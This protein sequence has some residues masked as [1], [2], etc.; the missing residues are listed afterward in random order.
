MTN[1]DWLFEDKTIIESP[2]SPKQFEYKVISAKTACDLNAKWHSRLPIIDWSNV[3]RNT[4]SICFGAM[5]KGQW[6]AIAI[7][8]S[9]VAQN[10]F[11]YGKQILELRRMAIS[12]ACPRNTATNML[13]FMRKHIVKAFPEI[14]LLISYQDTEVHNGT[15]YKADNWLDVADSPGYSWT[16]EK[17]TRNVEQSLAV[18]KRWEFYIHDF[19]EDPND[20]IFSDIRLI[21]DDLND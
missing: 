14:A 12:D 5:Y 4:H 18:K 1:P 7:W 13:S 8:S 21:G 6:F 17:R 16:N 11:K 2:S 20:A 10:R 3:V 15:I 9:P 19:I